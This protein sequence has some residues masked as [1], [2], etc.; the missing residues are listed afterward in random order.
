[1]TIHSETTADDLI[2]LFPPGTRQDSD[3][4]LMVG[5]CRLDSVAEQFGTPAI[6]VDEERVAAAGRRLPRGVPQLAGRAAM[7]RSPRS[8][9]RAPRSS[10]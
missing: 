6:V 9:S 2:G 5:G 4:M 7:S 8:P 3:G 1:M 10:G